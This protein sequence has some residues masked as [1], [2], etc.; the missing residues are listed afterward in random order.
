[1]TDHRCIQFLHICCPPN[2]SVRLAAPFHP[3]S[4]CSRASWR[5]RFQRPIIKPQSSGVNY[6][7]PVSNCHITGLSKQK[8]W[9]TAGGRG[10]VRRLLQPFVSSTWACQITKWSLIIL[11]LPRPLIFSSQIHQKL[12]NMTQSHDTIIFHLQS[13]LR[14]PYFFQ[15]NSHFFQEIHWNSPKN[16]PRRRPPLRSSVSLARS[17]ASFARAAAARASSEALAT[18]SGITEKWQ[19]SWDDL[20]EVMAIQWEFQWEFNGISMGF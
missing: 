3:A 16:P 11:N 1:M 2:F 17:S 13:A 7:F 20:M 15:K 19:I 8:W 12:W 5:Q 6:T 18:A 10:K 14:F 9:K 4:N